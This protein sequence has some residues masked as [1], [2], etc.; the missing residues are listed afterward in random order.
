MPVQ[1]S[2]VELW[3]DRY[4]PPGGHS[5][6]PW[7]ADSVVCARCGKVELVQN[8]TCMICGIPGE[9]TSRLRKVTLPGFERAGKLCGVCYDEFAERTTIREWSVEQA[10]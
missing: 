9:T 4:C 7:G 3:L 1:S 8:R 6:V 5:L 10:S 2:W